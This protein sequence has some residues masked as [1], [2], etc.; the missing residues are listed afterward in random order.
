MAFLH[1]FK[2][3]AENKFFSM[4][5]QYDIFIIRAGSPINGGIMF[6][7]LKE[8]V[9]IVSERFENLWRHL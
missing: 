4:I 6:E 1:S 8:R 5:C 3:G 7:D 9:K 2:N